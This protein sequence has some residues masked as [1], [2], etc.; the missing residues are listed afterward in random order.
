LNIEIVNSV[1]NVKYLYKYLTKGS[2]KIVVEY[3]NKSKDITNDE[4]EV[5]LH[6]RYI[7]VSEAFWRFY[8]FP[9]AE[10]WPSV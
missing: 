10:N 9:I 7:S 6:K 8:E 4:I 1:E 2:D 3:K 5:F